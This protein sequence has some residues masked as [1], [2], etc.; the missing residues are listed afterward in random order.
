MKTFHF[1]FEAMASGCEI[2]LVTDSKEEAQE[3]ARFAID[4]I[5]RIE[6]KYS[7]YRAESIV[8]L[9]NAAAGV[10]F[11]ECDDE[12]LSLVHYADTLYESSGGLF[13][14]TSGI[15]RKAWTFKNP[16]VPD[17]AR[18][19]PLLELIDWKSVERRGNA[20]R[21]PSVGMELDFGGFGKEY[22]ADRAATIVFEQGVKHGYVNM[23][24]DIRVVGPKPDGS[25]WMIGIQH[26][27]Q[28]DLALAS[29]PLHAGAL[30]TS[31]DYER[32]FEADGKR[33]CHIINPQS[34]YPVTCWQ[35]VT[36][37]TPLAITAGSYSTIAMLKEA[38]G[39]AFLEDSGMGYLAVDQRGKIYHK[40][41]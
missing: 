2:V 30:A 29:I 11:V 38:D 33:Y 7:R 22:A 41:A 25:P 21:L 6:R 9:I 3:V 35:S 23:A 10:G 28:K 37:V 31:G 39:L 8:S 16:V 13:D 32:Y 20:L 40:N 26:P 4:E 17:P 18:L 36:V 34:G 14:I 12:T 1:G 24:G 27:R 15:L 5:S 19:F